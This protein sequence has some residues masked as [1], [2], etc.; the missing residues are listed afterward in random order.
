MALKNYLVKILPLNWTF[1]EP[2]DQD[3]KF[4]G[5]RF[6]ELD[7]NTGDLN[8]FFITGNDFSKEKFFE[9]EWNKDN[10]SSFEVNI[11]DKFDPFAKPT[12]GDRE[13]LP[14]M[15]RY[16]KVEITD[17]FVDNF[18]E[19]DK[20]LYTME[21]VEY[22]K[23]FLEVRVFIESIR[24]VKN[25][26]EWIPTY[27]I[28]PSIFVQFSDEKSAT[29]IYNKLNISDYKSDW[30]IANNEKEC[31]FLDSS[32]MLRYYPS[33][34]EGSQYMLSKERDFY[35]FDDDSKTTEVFSLCKEFYFATD[36][37]PKRYSFPFSL[38]KENYRRLKSISD[39]KRGSF[40]NRFCSLF[41]KKD[42]G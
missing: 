42:N 26:D 30:E 38:L 35:G 22:A 28:Y 15:V 10:V 18:K 16:H 2:F 8:F 27:G 6:N 9:G 11:V 12:R 3:Q 24:K 19:F 21:R 25:K 41:K 32:N 7:D 29:K 17:K 39:K 33:S 34:G 20:V 5:V 23:V 40:W 13:S 36:G 31:I 1:D 37:N 14:L 4:I